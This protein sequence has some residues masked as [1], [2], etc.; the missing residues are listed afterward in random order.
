MKSS[1]DFVSAN[2]F[3]EHSRSFDCECFHFKCEQI[4]KGQRKSK[5]NSKK[6]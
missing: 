1:A 3:I 5:K 2:S 6:Y 4:V